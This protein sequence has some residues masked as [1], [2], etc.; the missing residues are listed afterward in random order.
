[1]K[2]KPI[3][4]RTMAL[5]LV[6]IYIAGVILGIFVVSYLVS[7]AKREKLTGMT[8]TMATQYQQDGTAAPSTMSGRAILIYSVD[9]QLV[10]QFA[11]SGYPIYFDFA[12]EGQKH[13]SRVLEG[14]SFTH[15]ILFAPNETTLGY[16][17]LLYVGVP[18]TEGDTVTGAFFWV[19]ELRDL[20]ETILAVI[21]TFTVVFAVVTIFILLNLHTQRKYEQMR[22][23]YIDNIT[24]ELKTPVASIKALAEALSDG[25]EKSPTDRNVYY[26][27]IL[28]EANRQERMICDVLELS[29]LQNYNMDFSRT[30]V[31][32]GSL[33]GSVLE[34]YAS[35]CDLT[36]IHF[37]VD[38]SL[39][40]LPEL[41]TSTQYIPVVLE[42]L[43]D[44]AL[45]F[46]P[47]DG[48]I[49]VS[50]QLARKKAT[51]TISDNGRGI[52]KEELPHIFERFYKVNRS[53]NLA[54]SG[55]GLAIAKEII[56]N[57]HERLW[58]DSKEGQGT[59]ASFTITLKRSAS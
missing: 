21:C 19:M 43:L 52:S 41:Y 56:D 47:E 42:V 37:V 5:I 1:M 49:R 33:F 59:E 55:L 36:G 28:R 31:S 17:S 13:V 16:T 51:I 12:A 18:L 38:D 2:R 48:E 54:G 3:S 10:E 40:Q 22:R 24:H 34:K 25:M 46:A 8:S 20:L 9:G 39:T 44:N 32:S 30:A 14:K 27:M 15:L 7:G 4:N 35:L 50:A 58:I 45:K 6:G 11:G 29:K 26:G 23:D 57:M 53:D